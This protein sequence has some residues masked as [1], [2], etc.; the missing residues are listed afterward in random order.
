MCVLPFGLIAGPRTTA[1]YGNSAV[2]KQFK[3]SNN[4]RYPENSR[5][6]SLPIALTLLRGGAD[7]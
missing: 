5:I 1:N 2:R 7:S 4:H 6:L 3:D